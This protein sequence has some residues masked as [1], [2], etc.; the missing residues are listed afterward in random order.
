MSD[1]PAVA[2]LPPIAGVKDPAV[3]SYLEAL[4]QMMLVRNGQTR[5]NS[6]RFITAK[7]FEQAVLQAVNGESTSGSK[8]SLAESVLSIIKAANK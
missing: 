7:E 1:R 3:R 8:N 6:E 5:D 2:N 4:T